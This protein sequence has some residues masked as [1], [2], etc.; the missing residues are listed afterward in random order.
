MFTCLNIIII[1]II[2]IIMIGITALERGED[3]KQTQHDVKIHVNRINNI[4]GNGGLLV[5]CE[6]RSE[7]EF[8]LAQRLAYFASSDI[9]MI[10]STRD[11]LN[12]LPMEF[13]LARH[14]AGNLSCDGSPP[15]EGGGFI[16]SHVADVVLFRY[17]K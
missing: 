1:I 4:Y 6:E 3:Y 15:T 14:H 13:T 2:I 5:H 17:V 12:R 9:L 7:K 8:R 11:G 16:D 10:T